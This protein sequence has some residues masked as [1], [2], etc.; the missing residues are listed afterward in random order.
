MRDEGGARRED[1]PERTTE[2]TRAPTE[3]CNGGAANRRVLTSVKTM[4]MKHTETEINSK[5]GCIGED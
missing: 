4:D 2:M 3:I 1:T 5:G